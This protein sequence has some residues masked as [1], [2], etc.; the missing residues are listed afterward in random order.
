MP[1]KQRVE[2]P[3]SRYESLDRDRGCLTLFAT[4]YHTP[5]CRL[6]NEPKESYVSKTNCVDDEERSDEPLIQREKL[7]DGIPAVEAKYELQNRENG[8]LHFILL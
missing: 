5:N 1:R 3:D 6:L 8:H 7:C 2:K 4:A